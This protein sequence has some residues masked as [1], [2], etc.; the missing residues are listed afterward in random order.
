MTSTPAQPSTAPATPLWAET[1]GVRPFGPRLVAELVEAAVRQG[2][3]RVLHIGCTDGELLGGLE[4]AGLSVHFVGIEHH[5]ASARRALMRFPK[6]R[7]LDGMPAKV[8]ERL[9]GPFDLTILSRLPLGEDQ[10]PVDEIVQRVWQRTGQGLVVEAQDEGRGDAL[11]L[12]PGALV[13]LATDLAPHW[14]C[15]RDAAQGRTVMT[16]AR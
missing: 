4:L 8:L 15:H 5:L 1:A 12:S 9:P 2:A 3:R 7:F 16:L 11:K 10:P 6:A 14:A 13:G